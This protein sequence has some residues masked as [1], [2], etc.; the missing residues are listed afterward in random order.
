[1]IEFQQEL[2][3]LL[4]VQNLTTLSENSRLCKEDTEYKFN[5]YASGSL[6]VIRKWLK[7]GTKKSPREL[8]VLI[9]QMAIDGRSSF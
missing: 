7:D 6:G 8:A 4:D 3:K 1:M 5:F 2:I 9:L